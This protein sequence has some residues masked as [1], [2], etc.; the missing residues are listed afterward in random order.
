MKIVNVKD[1][2]FEILFNIKNDCIPDFYIDNHANDKNICGK[3]LK[4]LLKDNPIGIYSFISK[5]VYNAEKIKALDYPNPSFWDKS[6]PKISNIE[7]L[8][9]AIIYLLKMS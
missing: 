5:K 4:V 8:K 1:N 3:F 6:I 2:E 7:S 9:W